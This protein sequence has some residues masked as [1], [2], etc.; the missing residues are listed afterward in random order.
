M[1]GPEPRGFQPCRPFVTTP[2][3]PSME[4]EGPLKHRSG[5]TGFSLQSPQAGLA[6]QPHAAVSSLSGCRL[7]R[8]ESKTNP[9]RVRSGAETW[10]M[11]GRGASSAS[12]EGTQCLHVQEPAVEGSGAAEV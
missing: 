8:L 3:D 2:Q 1:R 4:R 9:R 6:A 11:R 10:Q 7:A 12:L 5:G